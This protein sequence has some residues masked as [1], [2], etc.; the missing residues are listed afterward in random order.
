LQ[1]RYTLCLLFEY[2][3]TL[4]LIYVA[5]IAPYYARSDYSSNWG[6]DQLEYLSRYDG[7]QYLRLTPL[8]A[9]CLGITE[10]Y[11][12]A[13]PE[14]GTVLRVL[15]TLEIVGNDEAARLYRRC[16]ANGE[17]VRKMIDCVIAAIAMRSGRKCVAQ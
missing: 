15:P 1:G 11:T 10:Q 9:W 12:A 4:G 14:Q 6:G 2:A 3:A 8:G 17:A 13:E 16:R 7:L 5:Y